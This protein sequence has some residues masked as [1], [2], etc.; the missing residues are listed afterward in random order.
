MVQ[1]A[2]FTKWLNV[3]LAHCAYHVGGIRQRLLWVA[4]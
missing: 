2:E 1:T 4:A 3:L